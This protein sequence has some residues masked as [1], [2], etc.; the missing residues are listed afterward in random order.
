MY[1]NKKA[2]I[3]GIVTTIIIFNINSGIF[4]FR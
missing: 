1:K 3:A 4:K 2:E